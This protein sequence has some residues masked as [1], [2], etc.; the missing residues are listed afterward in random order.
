V[1]QPLNLAKTGSIEPPQLAV[2][3]PD[4]QRFRQDFCRRPFAFSHALAESGLFTLSSLE[5][6]ADALIKA[7]KEFRVLVRDAQ[8]GLSTRFDDIPERKRPSRL[9]EQV[10]SANAWIRLNNVGD[11]DPRYASLSEAVV[12][13][14]CAL[15]GASDLSKV[16]Q[17]QFSPFI[18][19]PHSVTPFHIDHE[20]NFLCQVSGEKDVCVYRPDDREVLAEVEIERFYAGEVNAAL[21][22]SDMDSHGTVFHLTPGIG[23]HHP[24][25]AAHW[26]KNGADVSV[27][28]SINLCMRHIDHRAHVYQVNH[29]LRKLG[30][31]PRPPGRSRVADFVKA[32]TLAMLGTSR[33]KSTSDIVFSGLNRLRKP[34]Q[35]AKELRGRR[36]ASASS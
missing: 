23:V 22:R 19:S 33:P 5:G 24:P 9:F 30:L 1:N 15:A 2:L 10:E 26:V 35:I 12:R 28:V 13:E 8:D 14:I 4:P 34:I 31:S 7:G 20:V 29:L 18:S 21:Y 17:A 3:R 16:T 27:S 36:A 11:V 25:L 6:A 32:G